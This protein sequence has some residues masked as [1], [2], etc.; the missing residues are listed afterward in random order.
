M[1]LGA[2]DYA[3]SYFIYKTPTPVHGTLTNKLL[4][5]LK[6]ELSANISSVEIDLGG[7]DYG[8]LGLV[9]TDTEHTGML[10]Q[11]PYFDASN[12]PIQLHIQSSASQFDAFTIR[13]L[14][15]K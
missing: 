11:P 8:Y 1:R 12:Y 2:V 9:L 14:H 7:G 13:H 4:K 15:N 5:R 3:A 10:T 6:D